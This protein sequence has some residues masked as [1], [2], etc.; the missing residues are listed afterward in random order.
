MKL[1]IGTHFEVVQVW[2]AACNIL[3]QKM[4]YLCWKCSALTLQLIETD[5]GNVSFLIFWGHLISSDVIFWN[6]HFSI[7]KLTQIKLNDLKYNLFVIF[8]NFFSDQST[9]SWTGFYIILLALFKCGICYCAKF[10]WLRKAGTLALFHAEK[11][12]LPKKLLK[13][14]LHK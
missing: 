4:H 13:L 3:P 8:N 9:H 12:L 14:P 10:N 11:F 5:S 6:A 7:H 1:I 2:K